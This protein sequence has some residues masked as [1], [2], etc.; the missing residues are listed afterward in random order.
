MSS[1]YQTD[2]NDLIQALAALRQRVSVLERTT[3]A[4]NTGIDRGNLV[5]NGGD[6]II[7]N[8]AGIDVIRMFQ[9]NPPEIRFAPI[10]SDSDHVASFYSQD[11]TING[12]AQTAGYLQIRTVPGLVA[13]GGYIKTF[14]DGAILGWT[15][16]ATGDVGSYETGLINSQTGT[17]RIVGRWLNLV[18]TSASD[19][20]FTGSIATGVAN[21]AT[22]NYN[23]PFATSMVPII[24]FVS[25]A[26][27]I[28]WS[29]TAQSSASFTV[30]WGGAAAA[31]VLNIWGVRL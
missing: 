27:A 4:G 2:P 30:S 20:L 23:T 3:R 9:D 19:A 10:G 11:E 13:D 14:K 26:G 22:L 29:V 8:N 24:G 1:K 16:N 15:D 12:T 31:K 28:A 21:S 18:Q 25:T 7:K 17:L 5:V 6:I